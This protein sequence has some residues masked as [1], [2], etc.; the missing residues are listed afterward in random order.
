MEKIKSEK[1]N[2]LLILKLEKECQ[3]NLI[4]YKRAKYVLKASRT[5]LRIAKDL[6]NIKPKGDIYNVIEECY[7]VPLEGESPIWKQPKQI[8][9]D[10]Y[11][12]GK[13][14]KSTLVEISDVKI[15]ITLSSMGFKKASKKIDEKSPR[16]YY[17]VIQLY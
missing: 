8:R 2:D 7:R 9:E 5:A 15:G 12:S 14:I 3:L 11:N 10:L 13:L 4:A 16:Y 1:A 17:Q 6:P